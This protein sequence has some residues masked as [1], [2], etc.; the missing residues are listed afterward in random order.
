M[1]RK[2]T[3]DKDMDDKY[4]DNNCRLQIHQEILDIYKETIQTGEVNI[5]KEIIKEE[6][7][8][9]IP[10]IREELVIEKKAFGEKN[11]K[12]SLDEPDI[13]RIPLKD[14]TIEIIKHPVILEDVDIYKRKF[15][16]IKHI[17]EMLKR[18]SIH[19]KTS[20]DVKVVDEST[21]KNNPLN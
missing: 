1:S 9:K 6:R 18:E 14:E 16:D 5:H 20:G 10:V 15:K 4:Y 7:I 2:F 8:I 11:S 3:S 21:T 19:I 12:E 17:K 13:I